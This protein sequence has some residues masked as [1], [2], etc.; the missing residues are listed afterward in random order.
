[1]KTLARMGTGDRLLQKVR[2][3]LIRF[4]WKVKSTIQMRQKTAFHNADLL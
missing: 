4:R 3:E 1:M 2:R